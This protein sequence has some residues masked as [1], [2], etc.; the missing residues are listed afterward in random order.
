MKEAS[1]E[2]FCT[3]LARA[4]RISGE[5]IVASLK[6]KGILTFSTDGTGIKRKEAFVLLKNA[7]DYLNQTGDG[8]MQTV[9][10]GFGRLSD[11]ALLNAVERDCAYY[12]YANGIVEGMSDGAFTRTRSMRP[13][14]ELTKADA[15]MYIDRLS[16]KLERRVLAPDGQVT[17]TSN[18]KN[19]DLY[20]YLLDSIP[21]SFYTRVFRF[22]RWSREGKPLYNS[23]V[24][25]GDGTVWVDGGGNYASP[26][27]VR[28]KY[29][30]NGTS[31][32]RYHVFDSVVSEKALES[33]VEEY[34]WK[35]FNVDYRKTPTDAGWRTY[36]REMLRGQSTGPDIDK[37]M[38]ALVDN[39]LRIMKENHT[40][41]ECDMVRAEASTIFEFLRGTYI[42]CYVHYRVV[43]YDS[44]KTVWTSVDELK[45]N[46][47]PLLF[48]LTVENYPM[49]VLKD[50]K[51]G[52]WRDGYFDIRLGQNTREGIAPMKVF[53]VEFLDEYN[54]Y[55][56]TDY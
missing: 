48:N 56:I 20:P 37:T 54:E 27:M 14:D 19:M 3:E 31:A 41:I 8:Q 29:G 6:A 43:S 24:D 1:F 42:R 21:D 12:V 13:E 2:Y 38:D 11:V 30:P 16:G 5:D 53:H 33:A 44:D 49:V 4:C 45:G 32:D 28:K 17:R 47:N 34:L 10:A 51:A 35:A 55:S 36:M 18:L 25:D 40:V 50:L 39:Y 46:I 9:A 15:R 26:V 22:M 52:E 7:A 23:G